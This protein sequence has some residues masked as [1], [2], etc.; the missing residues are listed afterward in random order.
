VVLYAVQRDNFADK[1][2][3]VVESTASALD[4]STTLASY[5]KVANAVLDGLEA[6]LGLKQT[7]PIVG[8]RKELDPDANDKLTPGYFALFDAPD[9]QVDPKELWVKN[10]QLHIGSNLASAKPYRNADYVLYS[11]AQTTERSDS[12]LLPFQSQWDRV[13]ADAAQPTDEHW[14]SAKANMLSLFQTI[15]ASPDLTAI[16]AS[17][18]TD[19]YI[20][21]MKLLHKRAVDLSTLS[22]ES[23]TPAMK[24]PD[25]L[26]ADDA[27]SKSVS[28][29]DL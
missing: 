15:A 25:E 22:G 11:L 17:S 23:F 6:L 27:R 16:Q 18:L 26:A 20:E 21:K 1:L 2:L 13:H 24:T 14:K 29:L 19:G 3:K 9:T 4:F 7:V 12:D 10:D 28:L 5:L 8:L